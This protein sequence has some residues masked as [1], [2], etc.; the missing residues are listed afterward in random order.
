MGIASTKTSVAYN[1]AN[2]RSC[3]PL[4]NQIPGDATVIQLSLLLGTE[5]VKN[6]ENLSAYEPTCPLQH[7]DKAC[8]PST[9]SKCLTAELVRRAGSGGGLTDGGNIYTESPP[10]SSLSSS[11][12]SAAALRRCKSLLDTATTA[13]ALSWQQQAPAVTSLPHHSMCK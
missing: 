11:A 12:S 2:P 5:V 6:Q 4:C 8:S 9:V 13:A 1:T 7:A 10:L 3:V